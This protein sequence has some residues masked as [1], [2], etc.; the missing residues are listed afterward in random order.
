[1]DFRRFFQ[2]QRALAGI[3][4]M[5]LQIDFNEWGLGYQKFFFYADLK[6]F[7][8][9]EITNSKGFLEAELGTDGMVRFWGVSSKIELPY[10]VLTSKE[11]GD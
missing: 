8:N 1:M 10:K 11:W 9:E 7:A 3:H 4:D 5:C 2:M 6:K